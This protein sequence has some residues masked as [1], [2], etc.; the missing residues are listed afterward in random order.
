MDSSKIEIRDARRDEAEALT[1]LAMRAKAYW[2]YDAEF[3]EQCRD[4]LT[5]T[6]QLID[7][8]TVIVAEQ[9]CR[10]VGSASL[11]LCGRG[12]GEVHSMFVDPAAIG[13]GIGLRLINDL[14][15]AARSHGCITLY[16]DSD[17]HAQ[18]FYERAGF[19]YLHDV[20]SG[21]IAGRTIPHLTLSLNGE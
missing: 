18:G 5:V 9:D 20:P 10:I 21:S 13:Q 1:D 8:N 2:G 12:E 15:E 3:M 4:E 16:V 11:S 6:P 19:R 17:P 7:E 14:F